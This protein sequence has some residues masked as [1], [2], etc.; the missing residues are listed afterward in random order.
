MTRCTEA[1]IYCSSENP[2]FNVSSPDSSD[3]AY[4][5]SQLKV[6]FTVLN[7]D[8]R[9]YHLKGKFQRLGKNC[10]QLAHK[11]KKIAHDTLETLEKK[12]S[13]QMPENKLGLIEF[14]RSDL[15]SHIKQTLE[16]EDIPTHVSIVAT[17]LKPPESANT[18]E[19]LGKASDKIKKKCF[20]KK[21]YRRVAY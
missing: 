18:L 19:I 15:G 1:P 8:R 11:S 14:I 13:I 17:D 12:T 10:D 7:A 16:I 9:D 4:I 5:F 20:L 2:F 3:F 6:E 21:A